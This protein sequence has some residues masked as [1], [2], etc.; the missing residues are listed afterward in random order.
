MKEQEF[1]KNLVNEIK[2][3]FPGC[4][5]LRNDPRTNPQGIPDLTVLYRDRWCC[6]E[7]KR[8]ASASKRPN[9]E[10]YITKLNKMSYATFIYPENVK[11]VLDDMERSFA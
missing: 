4:M 11:E 6:L 8:K 1:Q 5:V 10:Y 3:R 2:N 9:Q 7:C